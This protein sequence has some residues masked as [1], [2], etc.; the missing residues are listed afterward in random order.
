MKDLH[1]LNQHRQVHLELQLYGSIGDSKGGVFAFKSPVDAKVVLRV[2]ASSNF[3]W[4]HVSVSPNRKRCPTWNEMSYIKRQFFEPDEVAVEYHVAERD[5][6]SL[7][8][9]CLHL[10]RSQLT[11]HPLPPTT[12][13]A[14]GAAE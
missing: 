1:A 6:L 11:P 12:M 3:G 8:D 4:D 5:H 10:W 14:P 2:I 7:H 9:Y 13:V